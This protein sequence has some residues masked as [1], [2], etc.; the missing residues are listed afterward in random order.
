MDPRHL[1]MDERLKGGCASCGGP[2]DTRDHVP[3][4]VLL[5]DPFPADLPVVAAC[6]ACNNGFSLDE[7]YLACFI[8]AVR[9]GT[10]EPS[11]IDRGKVRRLLSENPRLAERI[12]QSRM[13]KRGG[14]IR[15]RPEEERVRSIVLK[16]ARGHADFELY[17]RV[18]EPEEV[19]FAP[20][21]TMADHEIAAFESPT[22]DPMAVWPEIGSRAFLRAA[23]HL[24]GETGCS[25]GWIAVQPGRYRYLVEESDGLLVQMVVSEYL[26][27][28]VRWE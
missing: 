9:C 21:A 15:W 11:E 23:G 22:G 3:S 24:A 27:C 2:A 19:W 17:S 8:A 14:E 10:S 25:G 5:D 20:I 18:D 1:F 12:A 6:E 7:Q 13:E 16:L 26:A 4:K 28:R